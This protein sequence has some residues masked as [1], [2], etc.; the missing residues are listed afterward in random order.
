MSY[1]F[2]SIGFQPSLGDAQYRANTSQHSAKACL[3]GGCN[4]GKPHIA[5]KFGTGEDS[6]HRTQ[7]RFGS[8]AD[9]AFLTQVQVLIAQGADPAEAFEA[10]MLGNT[11]TL[12]A[13][14]KDRNAR[15][16]ELNI[17][18]QKQTGVSKQ[19]AVHNFAQIAPVVL[20]QTESMLN[21]ADQVALALQKQIQAHQRAL[22]AMTEK[23]R[24]EYTA[25]FPIAPDSL[26]AE[27]LRSNGHNILNTAQTTN[28]AAIE[29]A[30]LE[31]TCP[32]TGEALNHFAPG[33]FQPKLNPADLKKQ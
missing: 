27:A 31:T 25:L 15:L 19:Q 6:F 1:S 22:Q 33:F 18:T 5:V 29:S 4:Y 8:S 20:E 28:D 16:G 17:G 3:C 32:V 24:A 11:Q 9:D 13:Q 26:T 10:V 21:H 12:E 14:L 7:P 2:K 23:E 30:E